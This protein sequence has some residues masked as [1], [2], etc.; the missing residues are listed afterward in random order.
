MYGL[1][2][3]SGSYSKNYPDPL[4]GTCRVTLKEPLAGLIATKG[5][6]T[7]N[8]NIGHFRT[9]HVLL[10]NISNSYIHIIP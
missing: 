10:A 3:N 4:A 6:L 8:I 5:E 9:I 2:I 1:Y 7:Q